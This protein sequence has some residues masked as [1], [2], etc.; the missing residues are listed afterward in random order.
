MIENGMILLTQLL[1]ACSLLAASS[2]NLGFYS[3]RA[4][5]V[6][7][8][9]REQQKNLFRFEIPYF[10][11]VR[12]KHYQA[13]IDNP[14]L[15]SAGKIDLKN[16]QE[17]NAPTCWIHFAQERGTAFLTEKGDSLWTNCHLVSTWIEYQ[18]QQLIF[19][20]VE[21]RDLWKRLRESSIP[22]VLKDAKGENRKSKEDR[23]V[24]IAGVFKGMDHPKEIHCSPFDD[25]VKIQLSTSL[26]IGTRKSAQISREEEMLYLGGFPRPTDTRQEG[27][28]SDGESFYWSFG[29]YLT[30]SSLSTYLGK[31]VELDFAFSNP[32]HEAFLGDSS[33][34]MSGGAVFNAQGEV[35]GIYKGFLPADREKK[36]IPLASQFISNS[37]LRYIEIYSES[38]FR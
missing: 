2:I 38:L 18:K 10:A 36:D 34:G 9:V 35:V 25:A 7:T 6:P 24:F 12:A 8:L 14:K 30:R 3:P 16:C 15:S 32:N 27:K 28:N 21:D 13:L 26:G 33:Q 20:G 31:N 1:F 22:F 29:E 17:K 37:G 5:E 11:E 23:A 4:E 19:S